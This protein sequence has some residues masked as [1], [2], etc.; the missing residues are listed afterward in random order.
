MKGTFHGQQMLDYN[1]NVV[2]GVSPNKAGS[3]HL[4]KPV[5]A[6]VKEVS[7]NLWQK[8]LK[9][10]A[11]KKLLQRSFESFVDSCRMLLMTRKR[12]ALLLIEGGM[13]KKLL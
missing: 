8:V 11:E 3:I 1:T 7:E 6:T 5:F 12:W 10:V 2:G 4:G 9:E 13:R